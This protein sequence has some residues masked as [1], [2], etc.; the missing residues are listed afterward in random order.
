MH[1]K[2]Q[3][4]YT[5]L[6]RNTALDPIISSLRSGGFHAEYKSSPTF[7]TG[8]LEVTKAGKLLDRLWIGDTFDYIDRGSGQTTTTTE[9]VPE[10]NK[11]EN[12]APLQAVVIHKDSSIKFTD[13]SNIA[14]FLNKL[15]S[16]TTPKAPEEKA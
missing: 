16:I 11:Y 14:N 9:F 4:K 8:F 7:K 12:D 5:V 2:I 3:S 1:T 15:P 10:L 13:T 6:A